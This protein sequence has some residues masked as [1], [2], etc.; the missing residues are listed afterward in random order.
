M[1][2][3]RHFPRTFYKFGD[4]SNQDV[5]EN[6]S[7]YADVIDQVKDKISVY[8]DYHILPNERPDQV[9]FKLYGSPDYH[10]TFYLMNDKLR[11]SGWPLSDSEV[12]LFAQKKYD[13]TILTTLTRI[14][15]KF[16]VG[17]N[18]L[19]LTSGASATIIHRDLQLGQLW[20]KGVPDPAFINGEL[21][22]STNADGVLENI[23]L[24]SSEIQYNSI[25]HYENVDEEWVDIGFDSATGNYLS[26]GSLNTPITWLEKLVAK[27]DELK[28]IRVIKPNSIEVIA[29]SFRTA[30]GF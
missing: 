17:Q 29:E 8:Q 13:S 20:V 27:N 18:M 21:I 5:F 11:E 1:N 19:G 9:S 2:F 12:F 15:D 14:Y 30:V 10:W 24:V 23:T 25:H 3:F 6:L 26:P 7:I 28:Q 16:K 22:T 4:E